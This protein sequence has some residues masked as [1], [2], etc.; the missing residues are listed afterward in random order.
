MQTRQTQTQAVALRSQ[1]DAMRG[2]P[3]DAL[4]ALSALEARTN[5]DVTS[6]WD[7]LAV[8]AAYA[9]LGRGDTAFVWLERV[10]A[11]ER[12]QLARDPRFDQLRED[13]RFAGW[14]DG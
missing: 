2:R 12:Q 1:V 7:I 8:A 11:A 14:I 13:K 9:R 3:A 4:R 5:L 10:Q 6:S